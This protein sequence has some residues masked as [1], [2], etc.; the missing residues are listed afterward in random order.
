MRTLATATPL[1]RFIPVMECVK[2]AIFK[3]DLGHIIV[4][5]VFFDLKD[6]QGLA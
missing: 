5:K 4:L 6:A 3:R 1:A 2:A